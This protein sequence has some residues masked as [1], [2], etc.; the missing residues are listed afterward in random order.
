MRGGHPK[1]LKELKYSSDEEH[2][3][4]IRG[5]R[6]KKS[7]QNIFSHEN[8]RKSPRKR[9]KRE[10]RGKKHEKFIETAPQSGYRYSC[11]YITWFLKQ[12]L[13]ALKI[14]HKIERVYRNEYYEVPVYEDVCIGQVWSIVGH[15]YE[16]NH[17]TK[18]S[19]MKYVWGYKPKYERVKTDK[20]KKVK[21]RIELGFRLI[22][23]SDKDIGLDYILRK[24][25][26]PA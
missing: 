24:I 8:Y 13:D 17:E 2:S 5:K 11:G 18:K 23:W 15:K 16:K 9:K 21:R 14:R 12:E 10:L 25:S 6:S 22:W 26:Y 20:T 19:E 3:A 1:I 7:L 4:Y